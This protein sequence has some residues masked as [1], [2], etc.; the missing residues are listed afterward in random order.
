ML[1]FKLI[2]VSIRGVWQATHCNM[3]VA[4]VLMSTKKRTS[5]IRI[6]FADITGVLVSHVC[7][8]RFW[9]SRTIMRLHIF[10]KKCSLLSQCVSLKPS[11]P[12]MSWGVREL[13]IWRSYSPMWAMPA[14]CSWKMHPD[15]GRIVSMWLLPVMHAASTRF[16]SM[17]T[18]YC[19]QI[20][21]LLYSNLAQTRMGFNSLKTHHWIMISS[22]SYENIFA[23][24][25]PVGHIIGVTVPIRYY[26]MDYMG[27]KVGKYQYI[28]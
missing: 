5:D 20:Q 21:Y 2:H 25:L 17:R 16:W 27:F 26:D 13:P 15:G 23:P 11:Q 10:T 3:M 18:H 7:Y 12:A 22:T 14:V 4:D 24:L 8:Y 6:H 1:G 19:I 28:W 9:L